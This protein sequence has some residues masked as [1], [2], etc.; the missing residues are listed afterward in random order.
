VTARIDAFLKM[1]HL[2]YPGRNDAQPLGAEVVGV[3]TF[4]RG[5][6]PSLHLATTQAQQGQRRFTVAVRTVPQALW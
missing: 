5:K 1:Q 2:F 3:L 6:P 4:T